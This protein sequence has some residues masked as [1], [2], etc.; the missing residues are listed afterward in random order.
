MES[1]S[2]GYLLWLISLFCH[3][4]SGHIRAQQYSTAAQQSLIDT[5]CHCL[6]KFLFARCD[7]QKEL[8]KKKTIANGA[9]QK[10]AADW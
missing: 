9:K 5:A 2:L 3:G 1:F 8:R 6:K 10:V 7:D 4:T